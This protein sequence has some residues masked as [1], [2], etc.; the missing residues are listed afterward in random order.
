MSPAQRVTDAPAI[1]WD[2]SEAVDWWE[3]FSR[4][5]PK[6]DSNTP[7]NAMAREHIVSEME[8]LG[9]DV[10][11]RAYNAAPR[12]QEVPEEGGL[13]YH[14][15]V[16]T[17]LGTEMP[18]HRIGLVSHYD[19]QAATI[20]GAYDDASGVAAEYHI[21]KALVDVPLR[22]SISCIFFDAEEQGLVASE[23][24]VEDVITEGDED[25][26]YDLVIGYD[27]TGINWPGHDWKMYVMTGDEEHALTLAPWAR[28]LMH[29][30]LDYPRTGVEVLDVHDRNSDEMN[31][32]HAGVPILRFAGGRDAVDY[33]G[34]HQPW[35]TV[36]FVY[37]VYTDGRGGFEAGFSTIVESGYYSVL[38]FDATDMDEL[39]T[40]YG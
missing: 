11:V 33:L 38:A 25:F 8:A 37:Q 30:V 18:D 1:D 10:E 17:K 12:G 21:C 40:V 31:F 29:D 22:R 2:V 32:K 9:F 34:Y 35:D 16:A 20:F 19:T 4:D 39:R 24:Y 27:M 26:V 23:K 7:T 15:I 5:Y 6:H 3:A 14:A 13:E 28:E 36:E